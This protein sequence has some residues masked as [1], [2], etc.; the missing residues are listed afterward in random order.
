MLP[1]EQRRESAIGTGVL[2]LPLTFI[3]FSLFL[4][5]SFLLISVFW[6]SFLTSIALKFQMIASIPCLRFGFLAFAGN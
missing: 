3:T 6:I 2:L 5:P 1:K 4:R